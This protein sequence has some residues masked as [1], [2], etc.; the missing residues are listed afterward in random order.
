MS[1]NLTDKRRTPIPAR[2][3]LRVI[4]AQIA[5]RH[6]CK[7]DVMGADV[8]VF[9]PNGNSSSLVHAAIVVPSSA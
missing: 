5:L 8:F 4:G 3:G 7:A 9:D 1:P 2:S 6:V